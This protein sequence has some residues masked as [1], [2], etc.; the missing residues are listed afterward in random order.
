[1]S[2]LIRIKLT[3]TVTFTRT[4]VVEVEET[5]E[6]L[7]DEKRWAGLMFAE[8]EDAAK[9]KAPSLTGWEQTDCTYDAKAEDEVQPGSM[10]DCVV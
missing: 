8:A 1:M 7:K 3:R 9:E 5:D 4:A 2:R 6:R 10:V